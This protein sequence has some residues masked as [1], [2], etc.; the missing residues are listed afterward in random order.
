MVKDS[1]AAILHPRKRTD[2]RLVDPAVDGI[3][4]LQVKSQYADQV[5][6]EDLLFDMDEDPEQEHDVKEQHPEV[7]EELRSDLM[8]RLEEVGTAENVVELWRS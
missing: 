3:D 8:R 7:T 2:T 5:P 4:K 6:S 1:W